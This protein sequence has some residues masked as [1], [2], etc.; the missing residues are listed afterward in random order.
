[1]LAQLNSF[2]P[3]GKQY[4]LVTFSSF[5]KDGSII[6][7]TDCMMTLLSKHA[8]VCVSALK[9]PED[10][11][12]ML[13][14]LTSSKNKFPLG[15]LEVTFEESESMCC[16]MFNLLDCGGNNVVVMSDRA[17]KSHSQKNRKVL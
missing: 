5:D 7:H 16:N 13:E 1:M 10:R 8:V 4:R 12:K 17:Y 14:E 2:L 15:I 11:Q 3:R 6:Y 9:H